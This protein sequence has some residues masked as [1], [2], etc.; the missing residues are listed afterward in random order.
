MSDTMRRSPGRTPTWPASAL[1]AVLAIVSAAVAFGWSEYDAYQSAERERPKLALSSMVRE[2]R[3]YHE[4]TG[5]FPATLREIDETR[6]RG[7]RR[8]DLDGRAFTVANYFYVLGQPDVH[9]ATVWAIPVGPRR[10]EAASHFIVVGKL[11]LSHWK[12]PALDAS[13]AG[14]VRENPRVAELATLGFVEQP[15]ASERE[16]RR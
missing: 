10:T 6:K 4:R 11:T 7:G 13:V 1:I 12:G 8:Y 2:L 5:R 15:R 16:D 9:H 14:A 3:E